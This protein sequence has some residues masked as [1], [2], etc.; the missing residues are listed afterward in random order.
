M[1]PDK[2]SSA[3]Y[4][5]ERD[6]LLFITLTIGVLLAI[7][8]SFLIQ[9]LEFENIRNQFVFDT[10]T[11][12]IALE[13]SIRGNLNSLYAVEGLFSSSPKVTRGRFHSFAANILEHTDG[14]HAL[15]WVP[16][17]AGPDRQKYEAAAIREGYSRFS[18]TEL[19]GQ[20]VKVTAGKRA[21]YFPVYYEEAEG[22]NEFALGF[23]LGA[24][25][26]SK[27]F[28][29]KA[30]D[31]GEPIATRRFRLL[32]ESDKQ[33]A[34]LIIEPI[35]RYAAPHTTV[36]ERRNN[37][38]GF[39][40]GVF[41][42]EDMMNAALKGTNL[43]GIDL[44][45]LDTQAAQERKMLYSNVSQENANSQLIHT[46]NL[47]VA[48][49]TWAVQFHATREYIAS[50]RKGYAWAFLASA[51]FSI[52]LILL[53]VFKMKRHAIETER[54][55]ETISTVLNSI[56]SAIVIIDANEMRVL[57]CNKVFVRETAGDEKAIIGRRCSEL[58]HARSCRHSCA[59]CAVTRAAETGA[60]AR[61]ESLYRDANGIERY[62][63]VRAFPVK[64][65]AARVTQI[66]YTAEDITERK[67]AE[68]ALLQEQQ[69][70]RMSA[71]RR[72]VET[73]LRMLQAQIEPHFLFNTLA[74]AISLID[75]EQ[76]AAKEMLQ[77]LTK[78]LRLS[79]ELSRE[80]TSTLRQEAEMLKTYLSIFKLRMG[81]RLEFTIETPEEVLDLPIPP[82]LLQPLV[83]NAVKHGI[84]PK[85]EGGCIHIKAQK[86]NS[87]LRITI[88]DT[89]LGFA[90][91]MQLQGFG[92]ENVTSR[93]HALYNEG[94]SLK[95]EENIPCGVAATIEVPL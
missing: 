42:L 82:M 85:V 25:P 3:R 26:N 13:K 40:I 7:L 33:F 39:V 56:N 50:H 30:R 59:D 66:V 53:Y 38:I 94:A 77:H 70:Q 93:L 79:L 18:F 46:S 90:E 21:E 45:L 5:T 76:K 84:E 92:L 4:F 63:E 32:V 87:R 61:R 41:R 47:H 27:A 91:N 73:Q 72:V 28:L 83:E 69:I 43:S 86:A 6:I 11:Y 16:R 68:N 57:A 23:D 78:S 17:V 24:N 71:E 74:N 19:N 8:S 34:F 48:D 51:L 60:Y 1:A 49:R 37:L 65:H 10:Q 67:Q 44:S 14:I 20:K 31:T 58:D 35:Y 15:R 89:G 29:D 88:S 12:F 22:G 62:A 54:S 2:K 95:L 81:D 80:G 9:Q 36:Q 52:S 75:T 64:D 55:R